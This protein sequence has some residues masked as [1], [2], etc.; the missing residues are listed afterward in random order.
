MAP[1]EY[2]IIQKKQLVV[3]AAEFQLIVGQ[4]YKV[5]LDEILRRCVMESERPLILA[6]SHEGI[7][8][9]HYARKAIA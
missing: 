4:I 7:A 2:S 1:R 8:G 9:G 6:K 3:C 5:G